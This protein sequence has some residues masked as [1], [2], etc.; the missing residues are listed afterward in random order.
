MRFGEHSVSGSFDLIGFDQGLDQR[1][2]A[3]A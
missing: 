2:T 3:L 1:L